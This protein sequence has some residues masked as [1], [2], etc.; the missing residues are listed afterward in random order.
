VTFLATRQST[1]RERFITKKQK[2]ELSIPTHP[3]VL[4]REGGKGQHCMGKKG[5]GGGITCVY[6]AYLLF[7]AHPLGRG[8]CLFSQKGGGE[9]RGEGKKKTM[10]KKKKGRAA[11]LG[12]Q[13]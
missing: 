1:D 2:E 13:H 11:C 7:K 3:L 9:K 6:A 10:Q 4:G 5:E 8:V 12:N